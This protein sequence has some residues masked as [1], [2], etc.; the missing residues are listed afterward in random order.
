M[1]MVYGSRGAKEHFAKGGNHYWPTLI[2]VQE[3][4]HQRQYMAQRL[5]VES[6]VG[7]C[8]PLSIPNRVSPHGS[9]CA[10]ITCST[11]GN[12]NCSLQ[13]HPWSLSRSTTEG[14]YGN[15][16]TSIRSRSLLSSLKNTIMDHDLQSEDVV[17]KECPSG[18]SPVKAE[19]S[20]MPILP[21]DDKVPIPALHAHLCTS[22]SLELGYRGP[23]PFTHSPKI[24]IPP[25]TVLHYSAGII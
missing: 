15:G 24:L 7:K 18:S 2:A 12:Q 1:I 8:R 4:L 23:Q 19:Q 13:L 14:V 9:A 6:V 3:V 22:L 16:L 17:N 11:A 20:I 5:H 25:T 21:N 10:G